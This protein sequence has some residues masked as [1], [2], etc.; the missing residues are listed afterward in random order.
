MSYL[1]AQGMLVVNMSWLVP[2]RSDPRTELA[3][4]AAQTETDFKRA[5]SSLRGRDG[6][7]SGVEV[8]HL[9]VARVAEVAGPDRDRV[10]S[11]L[12][13]VVPDAKDAWAS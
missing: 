2:P 13:S 4:I 12:G 3:H 1:D 8:V 10:R 9:D 7:G 6:A 11:R 5:G